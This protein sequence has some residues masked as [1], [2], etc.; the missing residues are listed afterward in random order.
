MLFE[1][2]LILGVQ[3]NIQKIQIQSVSGSFFSYLYGDSYPNRI[4]KRMFGHKDNNI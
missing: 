3:M 1:H 4:S 2:R